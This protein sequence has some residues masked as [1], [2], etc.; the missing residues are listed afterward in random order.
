[1]S[2]EL[3]RLKSFLS[4]S[5]NGTS[6][7]ITGAGFSF[8]S[9]N[10]KGLMPKDSRSL[11]KAICVLAEI[12]EDED[13][14]YS[15][16]YYL[17]NNPS[18]QLIDLLKS[19]YTINSV[20]KYH[21]LIASKRWRRIYTTNYDR[22]F[23]IASTNKS[24]VCESINISTAPSQF[25]QRNQ[26]VHLNGS[27]DCLTNNALQNEF[28]LTDSSYVTPDTL[29]NSKWKSTFSVDIEHASAIFFVG[30]SMYD[31]DI[32]R[33][34]K[35]DVDVKDKTFFI[36]K[37]NEDPKEIFKLK[38]FGTVLDIGVD[39]FAN[40]VSS[41]V[42]DDTL[43]ESDDLEFFKKLKF[44]EK[45][46][47]PTDTQ[48]I[49]L[50]IKGA[51]LE[52]ELYPAIM[53]K[54]NCL[55]KRDDVEKN[56]DFVA[57]GR[58]MMITG[59]IACG[60]TIYMKQIVS[61]LCQQGKD[62]FYLT[63]EEGDYKADCA[64]I[65]DISASPIFVID[66][67]FRHEEVVKDLYAVFGERATFLLAGRTDFLERTKIELARQDLNFSGENLDNLSN[68][69][70][71]QLNKICNF[72]GY[73]GKDNSWS[74]AQKERY[75]KND[76]EGKL[77]SILLKFFKSEYVRNIFD[78]QLMTLK[79]YNNNKEREIVFIVTLLGLLPF[80]PRKSL[81][82]DL[83]GNEI[84]Y[85]P[86]FQ[87]NPITKIL[88]TFKGSHI[89]ISSG[90]LSKYVLEEY[91]SGREIVDKLIDIITYFETIKNESSINNSIFKELLRFKNINFML[92][93]EKRGVNLTDFFNKVKSTVFWMERSPHFWLQ[94]GM[95]NMF[96]GDF[97]RAKQYFDN[98]YGSSKN[99]PYYDTKYIDNQMARWHLEYGMTKV[100]VIEA[101]DHLQSAYKLLMAQD[102]DY[103][104]CK[105]TMLFDKFYKIFYDNFSKRNKTEFE[106]MCKNILAR[107]S[108]S[109]KIIYYSNG[110]YVQSCE[111]LL[112][113][114]SDDI[115]IRRQESKST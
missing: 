109:N 111:D 43:S 42:S 75:L 45:E 57:K 23:E 28:K 29:S 17:Q 19:E 96:I 79:I 27:I 62:V 53:G 41:I 20:S 36:V 114:I 64:I 38:N 8:G 12:P 89:E 13:L 101:F 16:E 51:L 104:F 68:D 110:A 37:P 108:N 30:Y 25:S 32:K 113:K 24:K 91:F 35:K 103:Y 54:S 88:L 69:E 87:N 6:L 22:V 40:L 52:Y 44:L 97:P 92:P 67:A 33:I 60:K 99:D 56:A 74:V 9:K 18:H 3:L 59:D 39:E 80:S 5:N 78:E 15:S 86:S 1:M 11:S 50:F 31:L 76:C 83:C 55:F 73:W 90:I 98:A 71:S 84:I 47:E 82:S 81:V 115:K 10:V 72:I 58:N 65:S 2:K 26:C 21:E 61:I 95:A 7:L 77:S 46:T 105:Q 34:L 48:I 106:K 93:D 102:I 70:I 107:F 66:N 49:D 94:Y 100:D 14:Y 63:N 4:K 85:S 112:L